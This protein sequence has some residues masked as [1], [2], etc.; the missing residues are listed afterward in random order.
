MVSFNCDG[1]GDVVTKGKIKNHANRCR[2]GSVSCLDCS[3][4]F[5][6]PSKEL[7][8]HTQCVSEAQK[9]QGKLYKAK[10][11]KRP[12][13]RAKEDVVVEDGVWM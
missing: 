7:D 5:S 11:D 1:C 3:R 12:N 6:Y 4:T 13:K 10:A 9:Y 2:I 8:A